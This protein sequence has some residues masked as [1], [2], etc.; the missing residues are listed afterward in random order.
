MVLIVQCKEAI[1]NG[2]FNI[3]IVSDI[4]VYSEVD[5]TTLY[6]QT[7][8]LSLLLVENG[9]QVE[10]VLKRADINLYKEKRAK[11]KELYNQT[12]FVS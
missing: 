1:Y 2:L 4:G 8:D 11:R 9:D 12:L 5:Y 10:T 7:K 6:S 3:I